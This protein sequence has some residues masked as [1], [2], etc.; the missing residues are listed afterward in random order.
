MPKT[1]SKR[2][3]SGTF[4]LFLPFPLHDMFGE[5]HTKGVKRE[6]RHVLSYEEPYCG[7]RTVDRVLDAS[8]RRRASIHKFGKHGS[9]TR[10]E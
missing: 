9:R 8:R 10:R 2:R 7:Y 4:A 3:E 6:E 1:P 5:K